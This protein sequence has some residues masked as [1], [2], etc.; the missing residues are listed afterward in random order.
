MLKYSFQ[1]TSIKTKQMFLID[2]V[3]FCVLFVCKCVL[4][5]PGVNPVAV[6]YIISYQIYNLVIETL[7]H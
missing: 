1:N 3:L 7:L 5:P 2:N 4:L 6:K